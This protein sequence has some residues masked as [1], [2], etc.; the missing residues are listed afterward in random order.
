VVGNQKQLYFSHVRLQDYGA[1]F[2]DPQ[3]GRFHS[4]DPLAELT[5]S[6]T[7]YHYCLNNPI[8]SI[9]PTGMWTETATGYTTS[10]PDEIAAFMNQN[11]N[12]G[13]PP[14]GK[15]DDKFPTSFLDIINKFIDS[16]NPFSVAPGPE[17]AEE[18]KQ[19]EKNLDQVTLAIETTNGILTIIV[20]GASSAEVIAKLQ[21]G[22]GMAALAAV[23]FAILDFVPG[24][25]AAS[26]VIKSI[27][28]CDSKIL[29][30]A[31][32]TFKGNDI[33]RKEAN[34]LIEALSKGNKNPG[35]GTKIISGTEGV[36]EARS[37]GGARVY[38]RNT[39]NN[40]VE[41]VGYSNK[42]NQ[43]TVINRLL[44]LYGK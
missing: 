19:K 39:A 15:K 22:Q 24:E 34:A 11:Q 31:A 32:E 35:I 3:I 12:K 18:R 30:L 23:P 41:I 10:D 13:D 40:G 29:K 44:E 26:T 37:R 17:H 6:I 20:P 14:G 38:F 8:S 9:D 4:I 33:L 27:V 43:Q 36:F 21:S 16:I 28:K 2:Y 1:R 5:N 42:G 25:K 7:P